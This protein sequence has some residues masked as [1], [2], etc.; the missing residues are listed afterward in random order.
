MNGSIMICNSD[1]ELG[2]KIPKENKKIL[3]E[4]Y[5]RYGRVNEHKLNEI[6]HLGNSPLNV[7][8]NP[9]ALALAMKL[10]LVISDEAIEK[11]YYDEY[12]NREA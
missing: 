5:K 1:I 9:Y 8:K 2:K 10:N 7:D 12:N 6:I 3:Y 4:I 11:W